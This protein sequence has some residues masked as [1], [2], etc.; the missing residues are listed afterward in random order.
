MWIDTGA[1]P[2]YVTLVPNHW[3]ALSPADDGE[4]EGAIYRLQ[5]CDEG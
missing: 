3:L 5:P 1:G 4:G 2:G